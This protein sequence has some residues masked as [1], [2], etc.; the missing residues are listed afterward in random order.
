M[1]YVIITPRRFLTI[2]RLFAV[3]DSRPTC[4]PSV[5][6]LASQVSARGYFLRTPFRES[7]EVATTPTLRAN[8]QLTKK[9]ESQFKA[10]K[11]IK[12]HKEGRMARADV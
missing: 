11:S 3:N 7:R 10:T 9:S 12:R 4:A 2:Q 6:S 1:K 5:F 8:K